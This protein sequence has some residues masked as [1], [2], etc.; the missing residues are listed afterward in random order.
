M[1]K[2]FQIILSDLV[3]IGAWT[4]ILIGFE[5]EFPLYLKKNNQIIIITYADH[6]KYGP[7]FYD[8]D[9]SGEYHL[10]WTSASSV[11]QS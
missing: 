1:N 4:G 5:K 7:R 2:T 3:H 10:T 11:F 6:C 9:E 8:R